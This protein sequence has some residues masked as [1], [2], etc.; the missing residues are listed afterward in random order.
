MVLPFLVVA[1]ATIRN[2]LTGL[3][4]AG[5]KEIALHVS[6]GAGRGNS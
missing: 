5:A 2:L 6:F 4:I 3:A 1:C